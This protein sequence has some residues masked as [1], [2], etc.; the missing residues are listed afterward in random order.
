MGGA[1]VSKL[2]LLR[3]QIRKKNVFGWAGEGGGLN[4]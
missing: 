4:K 2:F 1:R 3:I